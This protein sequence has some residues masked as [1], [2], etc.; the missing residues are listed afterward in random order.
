[1]DLKS[2]PT[3]EKKYSGLESYC[4]KCG[5]KLVKDKNRCSEMKTELCRDK[6]FVVN[7]RKAIESTYM[8]ICC[9][10]KIALQVVL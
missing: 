7:T 2:C 9:G 4:T 8:G 6:V 5:V 1:M 3:C 10:G